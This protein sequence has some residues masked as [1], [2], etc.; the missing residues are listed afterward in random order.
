MEQENQVNE[1][2]DADGRTEAEV[3]R[4][5]AR[6]AKSTHERNRTGGQSDDRG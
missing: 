1:Q 2:N 6:A 5:L 4:L 3:L